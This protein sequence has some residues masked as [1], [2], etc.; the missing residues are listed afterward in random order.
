MWRRL[1]I[2]A[3]LGTG[4]TLFLGCCGFIAS[5]PSGSNDIGSTLTM[6]AVL[7]AAGTIGVVVWIIASYRTEGGERQRPVRSGIPAV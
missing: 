3:G 2:S 6:T 4:F 7:L 5:G 1:L